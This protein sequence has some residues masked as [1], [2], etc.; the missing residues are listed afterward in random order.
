MRA[1]IKRAAVWIVAAAAV[2][3]FGFWISR[4]ITVRAQGGGW[5]PFTAAMVERSYSGTST[6]PSSVENYLYARR[7]EGSWVRDIKRQLLPNGGWADMR[8]VEDYTRGSRIVVDPGTESVVTYP[9][10]AKAVG[11]LSAVPASCSADP[12]AQHTNF[13][14]YDTVVVT[15]SLPGPAD[16]T[17]KATYWAAPALNC[18]ALKEEITRECK[19]CINSRNTREA[20]LVS[21]GDPP[22]ALFEI[23]TNYV[24]RTPSQVFAEFAGRF[25]EKAQTPT[26][27]GERFD[28]VYQSFRK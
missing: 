25:P 4:A 16:E 26:A 3:G 17:R 7:R 6:K 22:S 19:I 21:E 1:H 15:R 2:G 23:P 14:G 12:S 5:V 27:T 24:E 11:R 13:L 18:F 9:Y 28:Q 10:S 8:V 20:L